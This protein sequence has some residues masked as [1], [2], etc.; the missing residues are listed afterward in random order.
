MELKYTLSQKESPPDPRDYV[1]IGMNIVGMDMDRNI[2]SSCPITPEFSNTDRKFCIENLTEIVDQ[3]EYSSCAAQCG[4]IVYETA[5]KRA[6]C[7]N[8]KEHDPNTS[9]A[10]RSAS[11]LYNYRTFWYKDVGM[12]IRILCDIITAKDCPEETDYPYTEFNLIQFP[13]ISNALGMF[14]ISYW[15][16]SLRNESNEFVQT[17]HKINTIIPTDTQDHITAHN[18]IIT[19]MKTGIA[20]C[21]LPLIIGVHVYDTYN[22][23]YKIWKNY[24]NAKPNGGHAM[25]IIGWEDEAD[26]ADDASM[27][28][29]GIKQKGFFI[30]RNSW[31][32]EWGNLNLRGEV[33]TN[34]D[35]G[36]CKF[37]YEDI[38]EIFE[39]YGF[40]T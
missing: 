40:C 1:Q 37:P 12:Y 26:E 28:K 39:C 9:S 11:F 15:F 24:K 36:C 25:C 18:E 4:A 30:I 33:A 3:G 10:A 19:K 27:D 2:I 29:S 31:G 34:G 38:G 8:N 7:K 14:Y 13:F 5:V 21:G 6:L 35:G 20:N 16:P 23:E 17:Y 22:Q 32:T